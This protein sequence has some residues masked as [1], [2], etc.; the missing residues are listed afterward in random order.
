MINTISDSK[1][2][3]KNITNIVLILIA[4]SVFTIAPLKYAFHVDL[5]NANSIFEKITAFSAM[6]VNNWLIDGI[7]HDKFVMH[8]DFPSIEFEKNKNRKLYLSYPPGAFVPLYLVAKI[9]GKEEIS[10]G[11][12]KRF[13]QFEYYLAILLLGLLF[14]ICLMVLKIQFRPLVIILPIILSSLWAFLPFNFYFMRNVYFADE[15]VV[16]LFIIFL[17]IEILLYS[18]QF[19]K[20]VIPLHIIS[21]VVL[22]I[23]MLTEYLFF[24]IV[25][26]TFCVRSITSFQNRPE[27]SILYNLF[28]ETWILIVSTIIAVSL[29]IIQLLRIPYGLRWLVVTFQLRTDWSMNYDKI[30]TLIHHFGNGFTVFSIPI[31]IFVTIFCVIFPFVRNHYSKEKQIIIS[32]V[33]IIVLS[34]VLHT[35]IFQQHSIVHEFSMLKYNLVFVFII[36]SFLCWIYLSYKD[37]L[38]KVIK[39]HS[40]IILVSIAL[41][42]VLCLPGLIIYNQTFY[43]VRTCQGGYINDGGLCRANIPVSKFIR[44]NTNYYDV[45]FSPDYEIRYD[46]HFTNDLVISRKRIYKVLGLG[47]IPLKELP[48]SAVINI[49]I[50]KE[51]L[52]NKSWNKL[53]VKKFV[54]KNFN[55]SYLFKFS[56]ES[57]QSLMKLK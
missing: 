16:L 10:T 47:D 34:A 39:K 57:F 17:I 21:A 15:A 50:S 27:K 46:I 22:I 31:L 54:C 37:S 56:K 19:E 12:V 25:F 23:G 24:F 20:W 40:A 33:S 3:N 53:D 41:L 11:F 29:F 14:Y 48:D 44:D 43:Y 42:I 7:T 4:L 55:D 2:N 9:A 52:Q 26:V 8:G 38:G 13:V 6:V 51:T 5:Q 36:F 28:S 18:K 35:V 49:L 30:E 1:K 32:W 45:I